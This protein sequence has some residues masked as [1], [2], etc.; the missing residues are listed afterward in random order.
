VLSEH[1]ELRLRE[2]AAYA[3]ARADKLAGTGRAA[4]Q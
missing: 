4:G 2:M 1:P 3:D